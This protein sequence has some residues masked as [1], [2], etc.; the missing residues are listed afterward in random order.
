MVISGKAHL[1]NYAHQKICLE[2][3]IQKRNPGKGMLAEGWTTSQGG[4]LWSSGGKPRQASSALGGSYCRPKICVGQMEHE[5][6]SLGQMEDMQTRER[7]G[8]QM[9]QS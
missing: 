8:G 1:L 5:A 3:E 2:Q 9:E 7:E 4:Y 6:E